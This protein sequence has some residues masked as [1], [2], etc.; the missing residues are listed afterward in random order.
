VPLE[1][2]NI[3]V[4]GED[5][6][7]NVVNWLSELSTEMYEALHVAAQYLSLPLPR[8]FRPEKKLPFAQK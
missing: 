4:V 6:H 8:G 5:Y 3:I 1:H 2:S 7:S